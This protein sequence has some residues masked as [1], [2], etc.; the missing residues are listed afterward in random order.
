MKTARVRDVTRSRVLEG[1]GGEDLGF[2]SMALGNGE[3]AFSS[4]V[5]MFVLYSGSL[6]NLDRAE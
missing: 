3:R 2:G 1:G 4:C 5:C 6:S